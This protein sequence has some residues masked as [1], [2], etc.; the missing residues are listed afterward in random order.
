MGKDERSGVEVGRAGAT[1]ALAADLH[2]DPAGDPGQGERLA[3]LLRLAAERA[4]ALYLLGDLFDFWVGRGMERLPAV[5]HCLQVLARS[6]LPLAFLPGNRDFLAPAGLAR[7]GVAALPQESPVLAGPGAPWL[8]LHGDQLLLGDRPYRRARLLLRSPLVPLAARLV[9][10]SWRW[11][12]ARQLR[13]GSERSLARRAAVPIEPEGRAV[14]ARLRRRGAR[15]LLCG[16]LHR[17]ARYGPRGEEETTLFVLPPWFRRGEWVL[18]EEGEVH[19]L[20]GRGKA[21]A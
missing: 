15:A 21:L 10:F 8:L 18:L 17:C 2:L 16:H 9:P 5:A 3:A 20:D 19:R 14:A 7:V 6:P 11:A 13:R 12:L 4:G 1:V